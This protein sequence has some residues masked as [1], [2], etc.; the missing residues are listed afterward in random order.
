[1]KIKLNITNPKA[2]KIT[3]E[4]KLTRDWIDLLTSDDAQE[5]VKAAMRLEKSLKRS[6]FI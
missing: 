4:G 2:Y 6:K 5:Q 1:M 3:K